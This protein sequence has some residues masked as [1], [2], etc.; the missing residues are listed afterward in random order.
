MP[1]CNT[2]IAGTKRTQAFAKRQVNVKTH[3]I[4]RIG[5]VYDGGLPAIH[6]KRLVIPIRNSWIARVSWAGN[7]IFLYKLIHYCVFTNTKLDPYQE[8]KND[9]SHITRIS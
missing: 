3:R 1:F 2:F 8:F 6:G 5:R 4:F 7:V 9:F